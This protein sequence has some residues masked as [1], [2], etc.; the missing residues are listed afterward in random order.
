M[1]EITYT[2]VNMVFVPIDSHL[3]CQ[4]YVAWAQQAVEDHMIHYQTEQEE[5]KK[6]FAFWT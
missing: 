4:H 1:I 2:L 6:T 5:L 3:L